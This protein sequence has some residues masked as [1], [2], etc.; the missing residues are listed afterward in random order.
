MHTIQKI[1]Q[2]ISILPTAELSRFREWFDEFDAKA[3]DKQI[4]EDSKL[5]KLDRRA[6]QATKKYYE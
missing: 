6:K 2:E 3:W 4:E 5:G 1:K